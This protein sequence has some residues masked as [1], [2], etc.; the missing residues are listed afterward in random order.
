MKECG[1]TGLCVSA[2]NQGQDVGSAIL[3]QME[4]DAI[5]DGAKEMAIDSTLTAAPF[6]R[7]MGYSEIERKKAPGRAQLDVVVMKKALRI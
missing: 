6:Y 7:R 4:T 1:I 5:V 2:D 3:L